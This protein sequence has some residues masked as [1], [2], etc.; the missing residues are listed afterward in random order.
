MAQQLLSIR[1][2]P[3][4]TDNGHGYVFDRRSA[5][6]TLLFYRCDNCPARIHVCAET[7]AIV[8]RIND[9]SHGSD[10]ARIEAAK[11]VAA[12]KRRCAENQELP[13]QLV[14]TAL[15]NVNEAIMGKLPSTRAIK[16]STNRQRNKVGAVPANP[17]NLQDLVIPEQYRYYC[18][19]E[20]TRELYVLADSGPGDERVIIFGRQ[21]SGE[22][23]H[24]MQVLY[25]D[26]TFSI[27]PGLFYQVFVL[28][29]KRGSYVL[30]VA[31]GLLPNKSR[32][33]YERFFTLLKGAWPQLN[34]VTV[35]LDFEQATL[36]A[37]RNAFP[38]AALLGCLYHLAKNVRPHVGRE[39]LLA[40]YNN[41]ADFAVQVRTIVALAFVPL[42]DVE[43]AFETLEDELPDELQ[44]VLAYFE[45]YYIG[46]RRNDN[47]RR[48][49]LFPKALWSVHARTVNNQDR[50][51]N[52]AEAA[53][54]KLQ[55][56]LQMDH[57]S[58][59]KFIDSLIHVQKE[60]D[61]RYEQYVRGDQ[62]V[63]KRKKYREADERILTIVSEY[64][65]REI[66]EYL[67]GIAHNF[68]M[69]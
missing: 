2:Q 63:P 38:E 51:K 60:T 55:A 19:D 1:N 57:P 22:W 28:L 45:T 7:G 43:L 4:V 66:I 14:A 34:P 27:S 32:E 39:Q 5:D 40:R 62:N 56:M 36:T 11:V 9:H 61:F 16:Q 46:R 37:I 10:V 30:P 6:Q 12:V 69:E 65:N 8:R 42:A 35:S 18:P 21:S 13:G 59:W 15:Q 47:G 58:L 24:L 25:A 52:H 53:H 68:Q 33:S 23:A 54:R 64:R 3:K 67:R 48:E 29:A 31:Y 41:D 20:N 26:G 44:P 17:A 49:P 50:T